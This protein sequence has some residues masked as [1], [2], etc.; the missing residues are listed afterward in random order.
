MESK[1]SAEA[2]DDRPAAGNL[3]T[4]YTEIARVSLAHGS[5]PLAAPPTL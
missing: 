4:L 2:Q 5:L 3:V 1:T